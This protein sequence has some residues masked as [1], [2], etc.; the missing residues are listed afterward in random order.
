M[1][2][3]N[4]KVKEFM[5]ICGQD[6]PSTPQFPSDDVIELRLKL[7]VEELNEVGK[8]LDAKDIK[9]V[10]Q[11]LSDLLYVVYGT[12]LAF[13]IDLDACLNEVHESN[14]TKPDPE[15]GIIRRDDG[16]ILKGINYRK[17]DMGKVLGL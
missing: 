17:P 9:N 12:G 14:M 11:E 6:L 2:S 7:I 8:A 16:K 15:K 10:A 1:K 5:E 3:N 13:G 4:E